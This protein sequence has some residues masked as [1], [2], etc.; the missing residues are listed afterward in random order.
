MNKKDILFFNKKL[1]CEKLTTDELKIGG[2]G[3]AI[4][5]DLSPTYTIYTVD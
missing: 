3:G 4:V 5:L 1:K 2:W